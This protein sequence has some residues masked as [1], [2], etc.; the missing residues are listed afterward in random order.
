M[1]YNKYK[2]AFYATLDIDKDTRE[3]IKFV[4]QMQ[5]QGENEQE[6][7]GTVTE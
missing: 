7:L 2:S 3:I 5:A 1:Y 6:K 4:N